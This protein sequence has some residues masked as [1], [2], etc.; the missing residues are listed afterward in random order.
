MRWFS[1][2]QRWFS[3]CAAV[4]KA[5]LLPPSRHN[6]VSAGNWRV[7]FEFKT[8]GYENTGGGDYRFI[9]NVMKGSDGK[10]FWRTSTDNQAN[11]PFDASKKVVAW[12]EEDHV[13]PVPVDNWFKYEVFWHRSNDS[14]GRFWSAVN[15]KVIVDHYGPNM[16][17]YNLPITRVMV[18]N[19]YSGGHPRSNRIRQA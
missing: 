4:A 17:V 14:D 6:T 15:G 3:F 10:L 5:H 12:S 18:N 7:Q 9:T 2:V 19:A 11:G 13:T 16:D 1:F 8:G